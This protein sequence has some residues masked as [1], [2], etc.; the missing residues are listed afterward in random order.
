MRCRLAT[1]VLVTEG[2]DR[3]DAVV[4][5]AS[6][7]AS[8]QI[9]GVR[10]EMRNYFSTHLLWA[11]RHF[12]TKAAEIETNHEGRSRFDIEHRAYVASAVI[13]AAAFIEA[14]L[15]ELFQ[16]AADNHGVT[17]DGYIAPLPERTR[18]LMR[19]WWVRTGGGFERVLEKAQ[20]LL[21][22]AGQETLD[23]GAQPFQDAATLL[24]LRNELLHYRPESVAADIDHRITKRLKGRFSENALMAD[25]GN[26]WW[27]DHALG[28]GCAH[29][30]C[31]AAKAFA[32]EVSERLGVSPN[33]QR[34]LESAG[35]P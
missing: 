5:P 25:S 1:V 30:A 15:N 27:P 10:I 17:D 24:T 12:A 21:V 2:E 7:A 16:D 11:A 22:F 14:F 23:E 4:R 34:T 6:I 13:N 32:D 28:A 26:A 3:Q 33:Y 20:L 19:E 29:W 18:L 35:E 9:G 31:T 8:I